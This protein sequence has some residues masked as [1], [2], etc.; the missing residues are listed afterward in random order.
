MSSVLEVL[1]SE[2][3]AYLS[4]QSY[5]EAGALMAK[6][7]EQLGKAGSGGALDHL[8]ATLQPG[9]HTIAVAGLLRARLLHTP[10][11]D[12]VDMLHATVAEFVAECDLAQLVHCQGSVCDLL[13]EY[14]RLLC[15]AGCPL[16]GIRVLRTAVT[17]L[18]RCHSSHHLTGA[19]PLLLRLC[20]TSLCLR[21]ALTLLGGLCAECPPPSDGVTTARYLQYWYYGGLVYC[22]VKQ[23][24]R[25]RHC[26]LL[27]VTA[28][29][30]AVS[31]VMLEAYRRLVLV[32]LMIDGKTPVL[33]KHASHVVSRLVR[34][35]CQPYHDL[36]LAFQASPAALSAA[37][38]NHAAALTRDGTLPL[39]RQLLR[40]RKRHDIRQLTRTFLTLSLQD[41]AGR[42]GLGGPEEA[43]HHL[44]AMIEE[45][46]I[47][48][49]INQRDGMVL[50]R[51]SAPQDTPRTLELLHDKMQEAVK[52]EELI[53]GM[54]EDIRLNPAYVQKVFSPGD[55]EHLLLASMNQC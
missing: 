55:E 51:D 41:V 33:P 30:L 2:V 12:N 13:E 19:H 24:G 48:A 9:P 20:L 3:T 31:Q 36:A 40:Q 27:A 43:Q 53:V 4:K 44:T 10:A 52:L 17:K 7:R 38:A 42:A 45:G 29:A 23:W 34:P 8:L 18:R 39:A 14:V 1:V 32:Q 6:A 47:E 49:S 5:E 35:A 54:E 15:G 25:A 21:P 37:L 26:L 50:F 28:P 22:A 11:S 16:R 46:E